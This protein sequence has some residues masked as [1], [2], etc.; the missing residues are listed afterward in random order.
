MPYSFTNLRETLRTRG[1][2]TIE[3]IVYKLNSILRGW[4]N[5]FV[6]PKV[7]YI[8]DT[9]RLLRQHL[10]YKLYKWL[11]GKERQAHRTLRQRPYDT[12]V[13][14]KGL[15]DIEKYVR[16]HSQLVKAKG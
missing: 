6:I 4:L 9:A 7:S 15:L 10:E 1:H 16:Q 3:W 12:L 14:H 5:Y 11:K 2:W 8:S 13:K